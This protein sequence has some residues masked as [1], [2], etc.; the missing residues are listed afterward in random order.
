M[1]RITKT[2]L[3]IAALAV[4]G[5][6][7]VASCAKDKSASTEQSDIG[8]VAEIKQ[9]GMLLSGTTGDYRPL[10]FREENGT[11]W[12]FGIEMT[13]EIAKRL[14]VKVQFVP[15]SWPTLTDDVLAEP[16]LFDL[17]SGGITITDARKETMLMS[18][19]YLVNGKTI[20]CR[21]SEAERYQSLADLNKPEV[22]VMVNP[23][24]LN[25]KFA[26]ENLTNATIIVHQK[27][28]EIPTLVA[29]GA[30]DVMIT[31]ITEAPYYVQTD[32]RLAAPLLD[33]PFNHGEIGVLMQK[34][35]EDL[36]QLVNNVIRQMKSDGSLRLLHKKYG[37]VYGYE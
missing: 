5:T 27:N 16:Q 4:C 14:G 32:A 30:A 24:G 29:E 6:V 3:L 28:E 13:G 36:L 22:R 8:K 21:A 11:Y 20:L 17:A 10:S 35:Q 2:W 1:F 15:T 23:G 37:L 33:K 12:G 26:N 25:E 31:E 7:G 9:R 34:G 19:G 18:E